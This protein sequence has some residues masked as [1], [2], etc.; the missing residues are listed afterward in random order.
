MRS[1]LH[2]QTL[3]DFYLHPK[4]HLDSYNLISP[5]IIQLQE[6]LGK[7]GGAAWTNQIIPSEAFLGKR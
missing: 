4:L 6:K 2:E 3:K 5:S 7:T 1:N